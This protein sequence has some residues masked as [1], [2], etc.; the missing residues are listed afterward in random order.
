MT[1]ILY[2][3]LDAVRERSPALHEFIQDTGGFA[4][5]VLIL[6]MY[7]VY[8]PNWVLGRGFQMGRI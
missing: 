6:F 4:E 5:Y 8:L 7:H 1:K 3:D 2:E